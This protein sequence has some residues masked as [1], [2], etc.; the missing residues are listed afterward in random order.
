M[1]WVLKPGPVIA[2]PPP[3]VTFHVSDAWSMVVPRSE[4]ATTGK[5]S[6]RR[7][8]GANVTVASLAPS[9]VTTGGGLPPAGGCTVPADAE[10]ISGLPLPSVNVA[11][12]AIVL[13]SS[14]KVGVYV[15]PVE[16]SGV[17]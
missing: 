6:Y 13:P 2:M 3:P 17:T 4:I 14:A 11:D 16:L 15:L 5:T 9:N 12:T 1:L 10:G 8:S 7:L